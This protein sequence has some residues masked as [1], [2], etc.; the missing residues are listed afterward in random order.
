MNSVG[1]SH[2]CR[3]DEV[4]QSSSADESEEVFVLAND[5]ETSSTADNDDDS[6]AKRVT[7]KT[8]SLLNLPHALGSLPSYLTKSKSSAVPKSPS[9]LSLGLYEFS[10]DKLDYLKRQVLHLSNQARESNE[11]AFKM[12]K[13]IDQFQQ[14]AADVKRDLRTSELRVI[15]Q[16][17]K[18]KVL[19]QKL[20]SQ[21]DK[22]EQISHMESRIAYL[23]RKNET[24][25]L[26]IQSKESTM[27]KLSA[28]ARRLRSEV[29]VK[30]K[31]IEAGKTEL[32]D[33]KKSYA[34]I[35][36]HQHTLEM[37]LDSRD[38]QIDSLR[39]NIR[40]LEQENVSEN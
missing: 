30:K 28:E 3:A 13:I 20:K 40:E 24:Q 21:T 10:D 39:A 38:V 36:K 29:D 32:D 31:L 1:N 6:M 16:D 5:D 33:L 26:E 11:K 35:Q 14:N 18:I 23:V 9:S 25:Q 12:T 2:P 27:Q 8:K 4:T 17:G 22:I 19:R 37:E 7:L 34:K 15:E